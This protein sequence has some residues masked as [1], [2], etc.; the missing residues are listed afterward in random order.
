MDT[1]EA[2]AKLH[3]LIRAR[4]PIIGVETAETRR[5]L[6][7]MVDI[8]D[9]DEVISERRGAP[10]KELF[11]LS[12][13]RGLRQMATFPGEFELLDKDG[14]ATGE[15]AL[16][17]Q[18]KMVLQPSPKPEYFC[19]EVTQD[20]LD[21]D[22]PIY[23]DGGEVG[24]NQP[25]IYVF[26]DVHAF[27]EDPLFVRGLRDLAEALIK[28]K[29]TVI[30]VSPDL[31]GLPDVL[32]K[33]V[34]IL[35]WP[36][37]GTK[38]IE[39]Q[40]ASFTAN[41]DASQIDLNGDKGELIDALRGLTL[42]EADQVLAESVIENGVL[43]SRAIN[44]VISAKAEIIRQSGAL[45]FYPPETDISEVGGL[46]ALQDWILMAGRTNTPEARA[47]GMQPA[48]GVL[49]V[50]VPGGGKSLTAKATSRL[51]G[52]PLLRLDIGALFGGLVGQSESQTRNALRIVS[53]I[54]KAILWIDEIEKG[55]SSQ[56]G[57]LDGGTSKRVLGTI[58]TWMEEHASGVFIYATANEIQQLRPELVRR[59]TET[60]FVDL[61]TPSERID[62][63]RIHIRKTGRDPEEYDLQ[64][65]VDA[66]ADFTGAELEQ[67]VQGGLWKAFARGNDLV[68]GD[69]VAAALETAPL[70]EKME[71]Q[72]R[73]MRDWASSARPASHHQKTGRSRVESGIGRTR[74]SAVEL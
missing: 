24:G 67:V 56:G 43:D 70:A 74:S 29:Q 36:L 17:F 54:G 62:I 53:A 32:S 47:F 20:I 52:V 57:E 46:E 13:T 23:E 65:V 25:R 39:E 10:R 7:A 5:F 34:K 3:R 37:P 72:I 68:S 58:L 48:R 14:N 26:K 28:R 18:E 51:W 63:L 42:A 9:Q 30:L 22:A 61:P 69:L 50:G 6:E 55:L 33:D 11:T 1:R 49:V 40:I 8:I 2:K 35:T 71:S 4:A 16:I 15:L 19:Y 73:Q 44:Y 64:E 31:S 38:E 60:F 45:E 59:F 21:N 12:V 41:L 66:T 27:F